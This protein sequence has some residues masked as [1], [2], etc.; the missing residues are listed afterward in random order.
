MFDYVSLG[1]VWLGY[2]ALGAI[3]FRHGEAVFT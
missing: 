2:I 1:M 3:W